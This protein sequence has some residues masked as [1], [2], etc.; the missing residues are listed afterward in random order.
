METL[1]RT[2]TLDEAAKVLGISPLTLR[3]WVSRREVPHHRRGRVKGIYF[4]DGDLEEILEARARPALVL[5][6]QARKSRQA[7]LLSVENLPEEF[8][9]LRRG[10]RS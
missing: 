5:P 3:D 6:D 2:Y 8:A 7:P 4:T 9:V 1:E 10:A